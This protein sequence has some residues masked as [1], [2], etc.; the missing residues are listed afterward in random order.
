MK[1]E[2]NRRS[3]LQLFG[4][5]APVVAAAPTYFFAPIGGWKSDVILNPNDVTVADLEDW[6]KVTLA[7][8][9][10]KGHWVIRPRRLLLVDVETQLSPE[11]FRRRMRL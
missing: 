7:G 9:G 8:S 4:M 5:A 3:F 10:Y 2:M 6:Y 1:M 11:E